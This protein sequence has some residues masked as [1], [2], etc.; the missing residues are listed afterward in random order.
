M[1]YR[2][3]ENVESPRVYLLRC[4][5]QVSDDSHLAEHVLDTFHAEPCIWETCVDSI[6]AEFVVSNKESRSFVEGR[7]LVVAQLDVLGTEFR[8]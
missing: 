2:L 8:N 6:P 7:K 1:Q 5:V 3:V 4:G